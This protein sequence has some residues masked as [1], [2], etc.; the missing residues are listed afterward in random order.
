MQNTRVWSRVC[1]VEAQDDPDLSIGNQ[2]KMGLRQSPSVDK[3]GFPMMM[4][5][6]TLGMGWFP[7]YAI[8]IETGES[9]KYYFF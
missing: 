5:V 6:D 3:E 2:V 8:D 9:V 4:E 1:V 7:G